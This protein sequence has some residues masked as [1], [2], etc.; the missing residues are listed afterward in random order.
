MKRNVHIVDNGVND[1]IR[2]ADA[3]GKIVC[4]LPR[5]EQ[6]FARFIIRYVNLFG[7]GLRPYDKSDWWMETN[8]WRSKL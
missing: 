3:S 1:Q 6:R 7:F 5:D 8:T 4:T 2:I